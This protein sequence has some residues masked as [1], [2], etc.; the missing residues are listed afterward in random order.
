MQSYID[1][2]LTAGEKVIHRGRI[3]LWSLSP[4]IVA[5]VLLIWVFGLGLVFWAAAA[6]R[7]YT[8]ELAVTNKRVIAKFGFISRHTIEMSLAKVES[9]QVSQSI[10][11]RIFNFGTIIVSGAGN[12]QAPMP[13]I[14]NPLRFRTRCMEAQEALRA[15]S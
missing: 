1:S 11:G 3:N 13:G 2:N 8:T 5:G 4:M 9:I 7:Y 12:P 15:G 14:S 6:I 10:L